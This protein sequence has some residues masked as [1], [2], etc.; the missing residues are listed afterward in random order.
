MIRPLEFEIVAAQGYDVK[1]GLLYEFPRD[2]LLEQ[3]RLIGR[4]YVIL[5]MIYRE[6]EE[7]NKGSFYFER[8][9][10]TWDGLATDTGLP[11]DEE[12][13]ENAKRERLAF[14]KKMEHSKN[15]SKSFFGRLFGK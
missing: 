7:W 12:S 11:Q 1:C 4:F 14:N 15:K 13:Y 3:T 5:G 9:E 2:G 6:L 10:E 8:A